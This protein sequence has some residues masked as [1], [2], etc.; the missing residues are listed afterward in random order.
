MTYVF[1]TIENATIYAAC[2]GAGAALAAPILTHWLES[3]KYV[4]LRQTGKRPVEGSWRG[5][6][7]HRT[8]PQGLPFEVELV[9]EFSTSGKISTIQRENGSEVR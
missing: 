7:K 4:T 1:M 2:I 3:K 6:T 9:L 8:G 5:I